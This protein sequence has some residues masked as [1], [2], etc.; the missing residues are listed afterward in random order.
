MNVLVADCFHY[1]T[2]SYDG[3]CMNIVSRTGFGRTI[4]C[5]IAII[6]IEDSNHICWVLQMCLRHGLELKCAIFTDQG[7]LLAATALFN[8]NFQMLLKLQLCLQHMIRCI[9]RLHPA[10][11]CSRKDNSRSSPASDANK[12]KTNK[13]HGTSNNKMVR[14]MVHKASYASSIEQFINIIYESIQ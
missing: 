4:L 11:F 14:R 6:P 3:V 13:N 7:P 2:P 8:D 9:R 5:A 10:L 1:K 12:S